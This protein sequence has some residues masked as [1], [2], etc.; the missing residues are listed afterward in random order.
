MLLSFKDVPPSKTI[1]AAGVAATL[2]QRIAEEPIFMVHLFVLAGVHLLLSL[3]LALFPAMALAVARS[4]D[5]VWDCIDE[6]PAEM[7]GLA[8]SDTHE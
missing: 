5:A 4:E 2:L 8:G 7:F 6:V 1:V 3:L